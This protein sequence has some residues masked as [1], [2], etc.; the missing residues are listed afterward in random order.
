[1]DQLA[2][3]FRLLGDA[4]R[5]RLLRLIAREELTAGELTEI[6]EAGQSTVSR[7]LAMLRDAGLVRERWEGRFV[8]YSLADG[9]RRGAEPWS[10]LVGR[11]AGADDPHSDLARLADVLRARAEDAEAPPE[12]AAKPQFVPGRS[13][14]AWA[15]ALCHLVPGGLRVVDLGCGDG[16]LTLEISRFA[17]EVVGVD[18]NG[19]LLSRARSLAE[20]RA[21]GNAKFVKGDVEALGFPDESFDLAVLS[22]TL[23]CLAEPG[24]ALAEAARVLT[25]GARILVLD[26]LPHSQDWVK[27]KLGHARL[28]FTPAELE[29]LLR[30]AGFAAVEVERAATRPHESFRVLLGIGM[31]KVKRTTRRRISK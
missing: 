10:G 12:G 25:P 1:V 4:T 26:L 31:R 24:R 17:S 6:V 27:E 28:G 5:L 13:W 11:L 2:A 8:Y 15:Q 21:I 18:R 22:Q 16:A 23:H 29:A 14:A 7:H 20:R 9:P 19:A 30:D 3:S